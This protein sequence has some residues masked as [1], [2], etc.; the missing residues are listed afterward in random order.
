MSEH[1]STG[2]KWSE[3]SQAWI[4]ESSWNDREELARLRSENEALRAAMVE[5]TSCGFE[6]AK[7]HVFD[8]HTPEQDCA[9]CEGDRLKAENEALRSERDEAR[10]KVKFGDEFVMML[11]EDIARLKKIQTDE[12]RL[13]L[14]ELTDGWLAESESDLSEAVKLIE[15]ASPFF[16]KRHDLRGPIDTFLEKQN[17]RLV[18]KH[19]GNADG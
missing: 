1:Y 5:C 8:G 17:A 16:G 6:Y 12:G 13:Q 7:R 19:R 3:I 4:L 11:Q 15:E 2:R 9:N 18:A 10:D 14:I